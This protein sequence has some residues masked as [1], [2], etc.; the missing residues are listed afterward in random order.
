MSDSTA[1][2]RSKLQWLFAPQTGKD[3]LALVGLL[4]A[5]IMLVVGVYAYGQ[6]SAVNFQKETVQIVSSNYDVEVV[7][8]Y[9]SGYGTFSDP[10][11]ITIIKDGEK[12]TCPLPDRP[13]AERGASLRGCEPTVE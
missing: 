8:S 12:L 2:T 13:D 1:P 11:T 4:V 9:T 5:L 6:N 3:F 10:S 7:G